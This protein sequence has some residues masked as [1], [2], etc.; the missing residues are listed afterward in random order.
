[1]DLQMRKKKKG[2]RAINCPPPWE[3]HKRLRPYFAA[4]TFMDR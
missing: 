4:G 1:M 3:L 2:G